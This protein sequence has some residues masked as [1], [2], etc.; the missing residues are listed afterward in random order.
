MNKFFLFIV[1]LALGV[2]LAILTLTQPNFDS[3]AKTRYLVLAAVFINWAVFTWLA[4]ASAQKE[5]K[6]NTAPQHSAQMPHSTPS[7]RSKA[8]LNVVTAAYLIVIFLALISLIVLVV[9]EITS[10]TFLVWII[11]AA[12]LLPL[13]IAWITNASIA[14]DKSTQNKRN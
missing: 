8:L 2:T 12:V 1:N 9:L 13:M 14:R 4:Y 6:P 3:A 11:L 10:P 7:E 5:G